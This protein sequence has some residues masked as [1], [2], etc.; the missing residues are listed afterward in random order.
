MV[1]FYLK[2][3]PILKIQY[4]PVPEVCQHIVLVEYFLDEVSV[5][6]LVDQYSEFY[7][8]EWN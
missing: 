4:V 5:L 1:E 3:G 7:M 8:N 2:V 6:Q